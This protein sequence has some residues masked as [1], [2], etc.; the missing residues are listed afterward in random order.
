MIL[1]KIFR[2]L[3]INIKIIIILTLLYLVLFRDIDIIK[4]I[5]KMII[6]VFVIRFFDKNH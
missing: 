2:K 3:D 5:I 4:E 6:S 1:I